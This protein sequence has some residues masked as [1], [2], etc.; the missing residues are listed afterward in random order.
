MPICK[1]QRRTQRTVI[2]VSRARSYDLRYRCKQFS[3]FPVDSV[4]Y[5]TQRLVLKCLGTYT[6]AG[7][8]MVHILMQG[9]RVKYESNRKLLLHRRGRACEGQC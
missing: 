5:R 2:N 7:P 4:I 6:D 1:W 8:E 9:Q 3:A